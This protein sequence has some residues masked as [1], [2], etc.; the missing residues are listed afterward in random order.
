MVP[1]RSFRAP[2]PP[3]PV[4][5]VAVVA[6]WFS[7]PSRQSCGALRR[8]RVVP[9]NRPA[10][11]SFQPRR[12]AEFAA[13]NPVTWYRE[14][15]DGVVLPNASIF[16]TLQAWGET[17]VVIGLLLSVLTV[18]VALIG[19]LCPSPTAWPSSG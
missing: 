4:L 10:L 8:S 3:V 5:R 16:A 17:A 9:L 12:V 6:C 13:G 19:C 1:M 11:L 15:L 18:A 7:R 14:L 2:V